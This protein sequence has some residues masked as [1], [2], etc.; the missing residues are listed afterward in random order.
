MFRDWIQLHFALLLPPPVWGM[1]SHWT[2]RWIALLARACCALVHDTFFPLTLALSAWQRETHKRWYIG[3]YWKI[4]EEREGLSWID[5][6]EAQGICVIMWPRAGR[7]VDNEN[8]RAV[9]EQPSSFVH[10]DSK[11]V[12]QRH[13]FCMSS[14]EGFASTR[15]DVWISCSVLLPRCCRLLSN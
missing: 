12:R 10:D 7:A 3:R 9:S 1:I 5:G 15:H 11:G 13:E 8:T 14:D 2:A 4:C 6:R